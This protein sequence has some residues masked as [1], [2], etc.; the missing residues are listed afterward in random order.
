MWLNE[1]GMT[2]IEILV[3]TGLILVVIMAV[4]TSL[5]MSESFL[6][7]IRNTRNRDRVVGSTLKN[8]VENIALFQKNFDTSDN[9]AQTML[10]PKKLPIAW[11]DNTVTD[12]ISCPA[13]PGRMGFIIQPVDGMPGLNRLTIRVTHT[14]LIQGYQ[15]YVYILSDE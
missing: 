10:N 8:V 6:N 2:F 5:R 3:T 13:C 15:D 4:T 7:R 11:D 12:A 14:T 9:W 1:R